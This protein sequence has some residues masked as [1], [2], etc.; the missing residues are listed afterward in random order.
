MTKQMSGPL[1]C[2]GVTVGIVEQKGN[3][4]CQV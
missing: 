1:R 2:D 3:R 4:V